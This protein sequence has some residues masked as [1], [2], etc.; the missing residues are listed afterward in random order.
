MPEEND[1][2][3]VVFA[4][5]HDI[6][7]IECGEAFILGDVCKTVFR[8]KRGSR[9]LVVKIGVGERPAAEVRKNRE[10]YKALRA[11]GAGRLL[12]DP[13]IYLECGDVPVLVME[14]CGP[15]F[16]HQVTEAVEPVVLYQRLVH[17]MHEVYRD[18]LCADSPCVAV[19]R[20]RDL[21]VS[22][23]R[24]YLSTM[25]DESLVNRIEQFD[26]G[27]FDGVRSCFSTFDFTPEDVFL[28]ASGVKHADPLPEA[29]GIPVIDLACFAGVARDAR[30]LPGSVEGYEILK[31]Y[32]LE[33][34]PE[35]LG[36]RT[37]DAC[38]LFSLGRALQSAFSARF[39]LTKDDDHAKVL[40]SACED[41]IR[42]CLA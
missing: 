40:A 16:L 15:D 20:T 21:L 8:A 9:K 10:G 42:D 35:L 22:Q 33:C 30:A 28:T 34:L 37:N 23:C 17:Q 25:V 13:V 1:Q 26:F 24:K 12:P 32:A 36:L 29:I 6:F 38:R 3:K 5:L 41:H 31:K 39:R 2:I 7:G 27:S 11:V 14:D 19:V 18:T 4:M